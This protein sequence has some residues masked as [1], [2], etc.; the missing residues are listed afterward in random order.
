MTPKEQAIHLL[1]DLSAAKAALEAATAP[2]LAEAARINAAIT[3]ATAQSKAEIDDIEAQLIALG[4]AHGPEIF[5][6]EHGSMIE[7]GLRLL[8]TP[9]EAVE[10]LEEEEVICKRLERDLREAKE[11]SQRL[12]LASLLTIKLGVNKA[13]ALRNYEHAPEWFEFYGVSILQR[14]NASVRPAPKPKG[15]KSKKTPQAPADEPQQE[16]QAA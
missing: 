6:D 7:N 13:Y 11:P 8:V 9:S 3:K 1:A 10:L 15:G 2:F 5:G 4:L 14:K 16:A 12:G